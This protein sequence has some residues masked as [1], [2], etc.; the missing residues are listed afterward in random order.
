[1]SQ[2]LTLAAIAAL[3]L[4][5]PATRKTA[6]RNRCRLLT[7]CRNL[8]M[9]L[10]RRGAMTLEVDAT[11]IERAIFNV[12]QSIPVEPGKRLTLLYPQWLP[13]KHGPRGAL[14]ELAGLKFSANGATASLGSGIRRR[15]M[16]FTSTSP[17][18]PRNWTPA[19]N[20]CRRSATAK[21]AL[22]SRQRC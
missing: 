22:S 7:L 1:M 11:D 13:G 18:A 15:S 20:S 6:A 16:P 21:A 19:I 8:S 12:K 10:M 5:S 2:R 9:R 17:K 3:A 14:A 4:V